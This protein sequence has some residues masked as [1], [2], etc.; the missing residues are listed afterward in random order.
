MS[1]QVVRDQE[2]GRRQAIEHGGADRLRM[3]LH[4]AQRHARAIA[5]AP[6]IK[7]RRAEC[8]PQSFQI[9]NEVIGAMGARIAFELGQALL[10]F[11]RAH[12]FL[13]ALWI[14]PVVAGQALVGGAAQRFAEPG[15]ALIDKQDVAAAAQ[16]AEHCDQAPHVACCLAGT[17][18]EE[19]DRIRFLVTS[20]G[21]N[22]RHVDLD[23]AAAGF[24]MILRH[25]EHEA[26]S[27]RVEE[28]QT[29]FLPGE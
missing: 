5:A 26:A 3:Q 7:G 22:Q 28:A 6:E 19:D 20:Q 4:V 24:G 10:P 25:L 11:R 13:H 1:Q 27:G 12:A 18:G 2:R 14:E 29:A 16:A 23:L 9:G 8:L 21:R 17:T 15:A